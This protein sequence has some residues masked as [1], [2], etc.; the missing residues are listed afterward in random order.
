MDDPRNDYP[1]TIRAAADADFLAHTRR[2][3]AENADRFVP[4]GKDAER[5]KFWT[6]RGDYDPVLRAK[7]LE[8]IARFAI[9]DWILDPKYED[10]IGHI[11]EG[12]SVHAHTDAQVGLRM[13]IR[14]NL[15]VTEIDGGCVPLLDGIPIAVEPGEAWLNFASHCRH[16]TTPVIGK[17]PRSI[18][19]Y[20]LQVQHAEA[21]ALY[22]RYLAWR[23]IHAAQAR[24]LP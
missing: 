4:N 11:A 15:L 20:G 18:I 3:I 23:K 16:A 10:L 2:L 8:L 5:R 13:H 14:I 22:S 7:K 6:L 21:F 9:A 12:G 17:R 24:V 19:S 1:F